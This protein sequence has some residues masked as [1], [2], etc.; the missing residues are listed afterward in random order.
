MAIIYTDYNDG[1]LV[2][3]VA[4]DA[5][6]E[7]VRIDSG[8]PIPATPIIRWLQECAEWCAGG[9]QASQPKLREL[10]GIVV[11]I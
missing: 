11:A 7:F 1:N 4:A 9:W 10:I 3:G 8:A 5:G 2:S 6:L